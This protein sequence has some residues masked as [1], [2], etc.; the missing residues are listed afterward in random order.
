[1]DIVL[2]AADRFLFDRL[3][4]TVLPAQTPVA[5]NATATFSS[6]REGAT[7]IPQK[8][9]TWEPATSYFSFPPTEYAW[10]SVWTRDRLERQFV[11][12]FLITW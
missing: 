10:Q 7:L 4:A 3:W 11:E 6:M 1:M 5:R 2:E 9:W 12:L 8:S